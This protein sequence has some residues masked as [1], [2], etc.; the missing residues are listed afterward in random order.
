MVP[1]YPQEPLYLHSINC[2]GPNLPTGNTITAWHELWWYQ[3]THKK[4]YHCIALTV[5]AP[6]YRET[7]WWSQST[8]Q[9]PLSLQSINFGGPNLP[10]C[11]TNTAEWSVV[12]PIYTYVPLPLQSIT[13]GGH[14]LPNRDHYHCR[15]V[16]VVVLIYPQEPLSLYGINCGDPIYQQEPPSLHGINCGDT[17][18]P[19]GTTITAI[20][21]VVVPIYQQEPLSLQSIK[22]GGPNLLTW[23]TITA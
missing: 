2:G 20:L 10:R 15:A 9:E 7:L 16:T 3:S 4:H 6:V 19:T 21:T 17:H 14:N 5:V 11:T 13:F 22:S 1:I 18:L 8:Q 23:T 12:V